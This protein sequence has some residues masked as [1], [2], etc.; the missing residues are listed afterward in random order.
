M[1]IDGCFSVVVLTSLYLNHCV[2]SLAVAV[3]GRLYY[4]CFLVGSFC[5]VGCGNGF[6]GLNLCGTY[7]N[8]KCNLHM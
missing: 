2:P 6:K 4:V 7:V 3:S 1:V 8:Y 5:R